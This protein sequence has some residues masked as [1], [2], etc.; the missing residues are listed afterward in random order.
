M[1]GAVLFDTGTSATIV[2]RNAAEDIRAALD[3]VAPLFGSVSRHSESAA[4]EAR[5]R[6]VL[7]HELAETVA[8]AEP[9]WKALQA[10]RTPDRLPGSAPALAE[11]YVLLTQEILTNIAEREHQEETA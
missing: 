10:G 8:N 6:G 7:V 1:L 5:E 11:D 4:V 3:G 9:Y 2:R